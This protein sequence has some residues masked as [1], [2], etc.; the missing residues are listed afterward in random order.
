MAN[1][2]DCSCSGQLK[3]PVHLVLVGLVSDKSISTT[4]PKK[5]LNLPIY[6]DKN[7]AEPIDCLSSHLPVCP[8]VKNYQIF[9]VAKI[10]KNNN[11]SINLFHKRD[12]RSFFRSNFLG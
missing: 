2:I 8:F 4:R 5:G 3:L 9:R 6:K 1:R 7:P 10:P 11:R 12:Y